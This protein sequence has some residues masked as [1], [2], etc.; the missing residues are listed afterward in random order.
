MATLLMVESWLQS[1]GVRL[2]PLIRADGHRYVL[3]TRDPSLY[4]AP[5][6]ATHDGRHPVLRHADE[7]VVADTNDTEATVRAAVEVAARRRIG[8]VVTTCDYYLEVVAHVAAALGLP[9]PAPEAMRT[10]TRKHLV[11]GALHRAGVPDIRHAVA[12]DRPG[13]HKA[14]AHVGFPLVAKPVDSNSGTA[15]RR[16]DD[17]AALDAAF[18]E[19]TGTRHNTRCQPLE[20]LLLVEEVLDGPEVSVE[21]VT[22]DGQTTVVAMTAKTV[23]GP[24]ELGRPG[25][26]EVAHVVPAPLAA[27]TF[28]AVETLVGQALA[29]IGLR[30]GLSHTEVKLTRAGPRIVELNPRQGGGFIFDLVHLVTGVHPLRLLVDLALGQHTP[31]APSAA[32][33]AAVAFVLAPAAGHLSA[34]NGGDRLRHDPRVFHW[35]LA[36]PGPV[37]PPADNNARIGHVL[38]TDPDGHRAA[39]WAATVVAG[40]RL[41]ID[42]L[43]PVAPV[44]ASPAC[45]AALPSSAWSTFDA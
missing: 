38:V 4:T 2:P 22:R 18:R 8:G 20:R 41:D 40:L 29:A 36:A 15:V 10:A 42:G 26:V 39:D 28:A 19:I 12:A 33:S 23:L 14:A 35:D 45:A 17:E 21:A 31:S 44:A 25:Y 30:H 6:G 32:R 34:I 1:T 7:V 13:A 16:V 11:R 9:G 5:V 27:D 24:E 43:G 37:A 3:L